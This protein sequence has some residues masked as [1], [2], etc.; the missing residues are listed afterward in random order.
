MS[1]A[2]RRAFDQ[3]VAAALRDDGLQRVLRDGQDYMQTVLEQPRR[4][5]DWPAL[6]EQIEALR[7]HTVAHLDWYLEQFA[8]NVE[9]NGGTVFA[10]ATAAEAC[11]YITR[12]ARAK[13][14]RLIV[15][16][17]SMVTEEIHLNRALEAVGAEVV[18]TD[19]GE[20]I[21]QL[22]QERPFHISGPR[23]TSRSS[24]SARF[25]RRRP[26]VSCPPTPRA[27]GLRA[28]RPAR[29]VPRRRYG[30][31]RRQLRRGRERHGGAAHQ[32]GQRA[33]DDHA[34][35]PTWW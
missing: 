19:L 15:K 10:A 21:I 14:A 27:Y 23:F 12:L 25:S 32:R 1:Q 34:A 20:F 8:T 16:S 5:L 31:S 13:Q 28:R 22:A 24:R 9:K 11:E 4:E 7:T 3:A 29:E 17:K 2:T 30:H 35:R 18:E 6:L 26:V 33:P